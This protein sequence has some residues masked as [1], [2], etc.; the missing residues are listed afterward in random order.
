MA[1]ILCIGSLNIDFVYQVAHFVQPGETLSAKT[2]HKHP[3][4]KGLN[5]SIAARVSIPYLKELN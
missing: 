2:F 4:G 1:K 3:G 5:Q